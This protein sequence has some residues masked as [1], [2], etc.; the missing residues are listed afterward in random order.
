MIHTKML[1]CSSITL[2]WEYCTVATSG[3]PGIKDISFVEI[4]DLDF[5]HVRFEDFMD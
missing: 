5:T 2:E 3:S 4:Y 1:M